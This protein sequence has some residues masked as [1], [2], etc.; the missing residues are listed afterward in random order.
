M[1]DH[2]LLLNNQVCFPIYSTSRLLTKAYKPYLDK[3]GITYPQY[4][5][6]LVLWEKDRLSV[7]AISEKLYLNSNTLSPLLQRMERNDLIHR[8]R[9][10]EDERSVIIE[11]SSTGKKLKSRAAE[12]PE[13]LFE[14][15]VSDTIELEDLQSM[16]DTLC[17]LINVL[18]GKAK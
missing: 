14:E 11:L 16:K 13:K 2:K 8:A 5:V 3:L 6:L 7:N 15:V 18:D 12:I 9:S 17:N 10:S 4:L 1:S